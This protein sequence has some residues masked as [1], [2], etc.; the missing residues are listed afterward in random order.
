MGPRAVA[1]G[2]QA[3]TW[4]VP[5]WVCRVCSR[6]TR[7]RQASGWVRSR[8]TNSRQHYD[9]VC[10]QRA[11]LRQR[12]GLHER[13]EAARD[14]PT[15]GSGGRVTIRAR[16][17]AQCDRSS[18]LHGNRQCRTYGKW[19]AQTGQHQQRTRVRRRRR[20]RC[21]QPQ[22]GYAHVRLQRIGCSTAARPHRRHG[23]QRLSETGSHWRARTR[24]AAIGRRQPGATDAQSHQLPRER[25]QTATQH[26]FASI[27][28]RRRPNSPRA[29][30]QPRAR[31]ILN[32]RIR[33]GRRKPSRS[34]TLRA[35][36]RAGWYCSIQDA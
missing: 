14:E 3:V 12:G 19:N 2:P 29:G 9:L 18:Q 32:R 24:A 20:S 34:P 21:T 28:A 15:T 31:L 16:R 27:S 33:R 10:P 1:M 17:C 35:S 23:E 13:R 25:R 11:A 22:H 4:R 5:L 6:V 7:G 30:I 8:V 36:G 26:C